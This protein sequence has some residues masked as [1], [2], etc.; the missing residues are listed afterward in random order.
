MLATLIGGSCAPQSLGEALDPSGNPFAHRFSDVTDI[1]TATFVVAASDSV[2]K[3]EADYFCDGTNDHV[4]I[5]AALD[6]LPATGGQVVLLDGT[7]NVEVTV[8]LD[9]YQTLRGC[10]RN[11]ILTTTT[12][13]MVFLSAV[14]GAGTEL[15]HIVIADMQVDG[16]AGL[17][18]DMGIYFEFVDYS[19]IEN[20]YSRRHA[21]AT[22]AF[23]IGILLITSDCNQIVNNV[24]SDNLIIGIGFASSSRNSVVGNICESNNDFGITLLTGADN[25]F[26]ANLCRLNG[27]G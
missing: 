8:N 16:G 25:N 2:H 12:A 9:S 10:G 11:T 13:D 1:R 4:Q 5:Q 20:V 7:F 23:G 21:S 15:V 18:G 27:D 17:L 22:S 6:A 3:Y 19:L 14:G 24:C 26:V